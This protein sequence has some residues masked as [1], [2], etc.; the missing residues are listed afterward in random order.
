MLLFGTIRAKFEKKRTF[1][2]TS[3]FK[4]SI[5]ALSACL[6]CVCAW[7]SIPIAGVPMTLQ[8]FGVA[9]CGHLLGARGGTVAAAVY[10]A[11]GA[12]GLPVFAGFG[13]SVAFLVGPTGGFL[14]GFLPLAFFLGIASRRKSV[15]A[16]A[17]FTLPGLALCHL[18]GVLWF[19]YVSG[20]T[21]LQ[22]F[23]LSSLPYLLKDA[24]S[25]L[26]AR[27]LFRKFRKHFAGSA[28]F[29]Q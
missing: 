9:F 29:R 26:L 22:A 8:T 10:L 4:I 6:I 7:V 20:I 28:Y 16:E 5:T 25:L 23:L 24:L 19:A 17:L 2:K 14:F 18:F 12:I 1:M 13:G 27:L 15:V 11:L 3:A 21:L